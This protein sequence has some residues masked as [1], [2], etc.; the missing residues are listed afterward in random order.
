LLKPCAGD[1]KTQ[2]G[3]EGSG[4][5]TLYLYGAGLISE[6]R[7]S[8]V[9]YHHYNH[10]GSTMQLTDGLGTVKA[11]Y[12]Y[13]TYGELLSGDSSLTRVVEQLEHTDLLTGLPS[14]K[15]N[16]ICGERSSFGDFLSFT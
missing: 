2:E 11:A 14:I 1:D 13:G 4:E 16:M 3:R 5:S 9:L 15:M 8:T 7:G 10:L 12:T 6:K